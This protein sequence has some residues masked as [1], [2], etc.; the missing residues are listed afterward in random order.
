MWY[1]YKYR[2][3][4]HQNR[5]ETELHIKDHTTYKKDILHMELKICLRSKGCMLGIG[6]KFNRPALT[7][8]KTTLT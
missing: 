8:S 7:K 6:A 5:R 3:I 4:T 2:Q 1:W